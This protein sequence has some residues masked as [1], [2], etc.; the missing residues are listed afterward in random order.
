MSEVS[1]YENCQSFIVPRIN[2]NTVT[3]AMCKSTEWRSVIA[4]DCPNKC[5]FCLLGG[6]IDSAVDCASQ[7]SICLTKGLE[8]FVASNCQRTCGLCT[9]AT[10][11]SSSIGNCVDSS[12]RFVL[13]L[14]ARA[15]SFQLCQLGQKWFL[16]QQ[17]LFGNSQE[18]AVWKELRTLLKSFLYKLDEWPDQP[19]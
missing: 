11:T 14:F 5:G 13:L 12:A 1:L 19:Q 4:Q 8:S 3:A 9:S 2:C 10:S 17:L 7:P 16:Y 15:S 6:C 18:A